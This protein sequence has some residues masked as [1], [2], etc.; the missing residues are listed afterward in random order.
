MVSRL[1]FFVAALLMAAFPVIAGESA[2]NGVYGGYVGSDRWFTTMRQ[3]AANMA[4]L[5]Q[6]G[7]GRPGQTV[8]PDYV[9][10]A[11]EFV[12][13][14][15]NPFPKGRLPDVRIN[16]I[17]LNSDSVER[18]PFIHYD[19]GGTIDFYTVLKPGQSYTFSWLYYFGSPESF[20]SWSVP[21]GAP[22]QLRLRLSIDSAGKGRIEQTETVPVP[23]I[24]TSEGV[25]PAAPNP[26]PQTGGPAPGAPGNA[27]G[28][29]YGYPGSS[30]VP[31]PSR[32]SATNPHPAATP[33][34][35]GTVYAPPQY[36]QP[37]PPVYSGYSTA[38]IYPTHPGGADFEDFDLSGFPQQ[39]TDFEE[40]QVFE[41]I[42]AARDPRNVPS[43]TV[44]AQAH[45]R[46][47]R[48]YQRKGD[49]Q[50]ATAEFQKAKHWYSGG[51]PQ[52]GAYPAAAP[53]AAY[54]VTGYPNSGYPS[55]SYVPPTYPPSHPSTHPPAA[56]PSSYPTAPVYA[57]S[58]PPA[59]SG[60][61]AGANPSGQPGMLERIGKILDSLQGQKEGSPDH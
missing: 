14:S 2:S 5:R 1:G 38:P 34:Q 43:P 23:P 24:Q 48:Y 6:I 35:S 22:K 51:Q 47:A 27:P 41:E 20:L 18:A 45:E 59:Q 11:A 12:F 52:S 33:P 56:A 13:P 9:E 30:G 39:P 49:T 26:Y 21:P 42:T 44:K 46:L 50:R 61:G 29:A 16:S 36:P 57:P 60:P 15:G 28:G 54:P 19:E 55:P 25:P 37:T 17:D 53:P 58:T 10:V 4:M 40:Q 31:E 32:S 3:S 7:G 8:P